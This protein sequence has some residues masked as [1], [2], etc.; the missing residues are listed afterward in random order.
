MS[1]PK[2]LSTLRRYTGQTGA[3]TLIAAGSIGGFILLVPSMSPLP[4]FRPHMEKRVLEIGLLILS[5]G[6]LLASHKARR[7]WLS[8]FRSLPW[9]SRWGLGAVLSLGVVSSLVAPSSFYALLEVGNF[10]L[11]F[12]VAGLVAAAAGPGEWGLSFSAS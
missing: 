9:H 12:A 1:L 11:L 8:V 6:L 4:S 7:Q 3:W 2:S 5:G 10:V